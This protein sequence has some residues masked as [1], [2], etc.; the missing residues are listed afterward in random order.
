[1]SE[2]TVTSDTAQDGGVTHTIDHPHGDAVVAVEHDAARV[3]VYWHHPSDGGAPYLVVDI[4]TA[5]DDPALRVYV[6]DSPV[7]GSTA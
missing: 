3:A 2:L 1:V 7:S 6:N 4:D 5:E